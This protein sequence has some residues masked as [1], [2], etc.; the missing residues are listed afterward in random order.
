MQNCKIIRKLF[1]PS[2]KYFSYNSNFFY[3]YIYT[4]FRKM[5]KL[6]QTG[7]LSLFIRVT[8]KELC[9]NAFSLKLSCTFIETITGHGFFPLKF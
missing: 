7:N 2:S 6:G 4:H 1:K 8:V 5:Q 3:I 9:Q